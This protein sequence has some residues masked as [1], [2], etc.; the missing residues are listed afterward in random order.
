VRLWRLHLSRSTNRVFEKQKISEGVCEGQ[1][2]LAHSR[3]HSGKRY[4]KKDEDQ[5][6]FEA[7]DQKD[8]AIEALAHDLRKG[9]TSS[10]SLHG[11]PNK[12]VG[13]HVERRRVRLRAV[14]NAVLVV[15]ISIQTSFFPAS[16]MFSSLFG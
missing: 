9:L 1:D 4:F 2:N 16:I 7:G 10:R 3:D 15:V 11:P 5:K 14:R 6:T 12:A 13:I 8:T